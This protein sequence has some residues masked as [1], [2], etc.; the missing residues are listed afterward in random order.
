MCGYDPSYIYDAILEAEYL[1]RMEQEEK[2]F[3]EELK[4]KTDIELEQL[5]RDAEDEQSTNMWQLVTDEMN[6]R[7]RCEH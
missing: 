5:L 2:E 6:R 3:V 1:E 7:L 4:T